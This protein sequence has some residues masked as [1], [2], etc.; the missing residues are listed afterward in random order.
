MA[1]SNQSSRR[2]F[3]KATGIAGVAA[4]LS[5]VTS[6]F[7][8]ATNDKILPLWER[9]DLGDNVTITVLPLFKSHFK[10]EEMAVSDESKQTSNAFVNAMLKQNNVITMYVYFRKGTWEADLQNRLLGDILPVLAKESERPI[11][12]IM[13]ELGA[14][15]KNGN[16]HVNYE[17]ALNAR[18]DDPVYPQDLREF[19]K[20]D[21]NPDSFIECYLNPGNGKSYWRCVASL[22]LESRD[23]PYSEIKSEYESHFRNKVID[24]S[25]K[26]MEI[27]HNKPITSAII[28]NENTPK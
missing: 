24:V 23:T 16:I 13:A 4:A 10:D 19:L 27:V 9:K 26:Q 25:N 14:W 7:A 12:V 3:L 6:P 18:L 28:T 20:R 17:G 21:G 11:S 2:N 22:K 1:L 5:S 8:N 15:D